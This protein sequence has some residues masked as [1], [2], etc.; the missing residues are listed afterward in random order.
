MMVAKCD[1]S[2]RSGDDNL[3]F[4]DP[5]GNA[6]EPADQIYEIAGCFCQVRIGCQNS[7]FPSPHDTPIACSTDSVRAKARKIMAPKYR[8]SIIIS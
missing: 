5:K 4:I 2:L 8:I 3:V 7:F 6:E 1:C